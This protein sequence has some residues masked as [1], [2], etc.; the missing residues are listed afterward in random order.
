MSE[1]ENE[2]FEVL[3]RFKGQNRTRRN[4]DEPFFGKQGEGQL[5]LEVSESTLTCTITYNNG[6]VITHESDIVYYA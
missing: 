6:Q 1:D 2:A 5:T 4:L 3:E